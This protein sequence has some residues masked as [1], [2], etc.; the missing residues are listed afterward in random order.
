MN[1]IEEYKLAIAEERLL[2]VLASRLEKLSVDFLQNYEQKV[3]GETKNKADPLE[4]HYNLQ[5]LILER[6]QKRVYDS[7]CTNVTEID[8]AVLK[9]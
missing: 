8:K 7:L 2:E 3:T 9:V 5:C 6:L 1:P 4:I